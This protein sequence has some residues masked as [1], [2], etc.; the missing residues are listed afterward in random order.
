MFLYLTIFLVAF[1]LSMDTFSLSLSYGMININKKY[2]RIISICVGLFHFF[3]PLLG[4]LFGEFIF[5]IFP[6]KEKI[7]IGIIFLTISVEI[8]FSLFKEKEVIPIKKITDILLFSFTVS[9]DSFVTGTCLDV[10]NC[11]YLIIV[12]IFMI[13]SFLFTYIGL[14]LGSFIHNKIGFIAEII[15][16]FL[17]ISLSFFYLIY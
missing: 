8:I 16:I 15:G 6:V 3:M 5:S 11:N 2:I 10:F 17:L 14:Y 1:S 9:I 12:S 4:N 7:I 13:V